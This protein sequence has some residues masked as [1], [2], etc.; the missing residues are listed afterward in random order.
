MHSNLVRAFTI[1]ALA[2]G[3]AAMANAQ[4]NASPGQ[5]RDLGK[6]EYDTH[7]AACHGSSG[8]GG[9]PYAGVLSKTIPN[10]T[11]L[12]K[13]N[14]GVFPFTRVYEMIDG[15]QEVAAHGPRDMPIWGRDYTTTSTPYYDPESLARAKILA[16]TEY[17][18]RLQAK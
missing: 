12:S 7:C 16:L 9:G 6:W 11:T 3:A 14:G 15:R 13:M 1:G 8:A 18:Y 10:L 4:Q 17:I 5:I 2:V